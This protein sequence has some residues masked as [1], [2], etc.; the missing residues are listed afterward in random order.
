MERWRCQQL[1][2]YQRSLGGDR[3]TDRD[4]RHLLLHGTDLGWPVYDSAFRTAGS[5][6]K[7]Y[8]EYRH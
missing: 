3:C 4:Y 8:V 1:H 5:S 2:G 7:Q 6:G